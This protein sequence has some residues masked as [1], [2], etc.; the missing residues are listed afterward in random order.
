MV[1]SLFV[2]GASLPWHLPRASQ[3]SGC[4]LVMFF[5]CE[6]GLV[7][8]LHVLASPRI[9]GNMLARLFVLF[10]RLVSGMLHLALRSIRVG[11]CRYFPLCVA[12]VFILDL[13]AVLL[14][15]PFGSDWKWMFVVRGARSRLPFLAYE[16]T[17][18][19]LMFVVHTAIS[20][21]HFTPNAYLTSRKTI[22]KLTVLPCNS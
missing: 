14:D 22:A 12:A 9:F 20:L 16:T 13:F 8:L 18:P 15:S 21:V 4:A 19:S 3:T 10:T 1:W 6:Q 2:F 7:A 17:R 5:Y 11:T